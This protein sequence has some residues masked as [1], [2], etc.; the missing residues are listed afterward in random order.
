MR[1]NEKEKSYERQEE[2]EQKESNGKQGLLA[3]FLFLFLYLCAVSWRMTLMYEMKRT[4]TNSED[5]YEESTKKRHMESIALLTS[6]I[7]LTHLYVLHKYIF[8]GSFCLDLKKGLAINDKYCEFCNKQFV[9]DSD[10]DAII[11]EKI[12]GLNKIGDSYKIDLLLRELTKRGGSTDID[13]L[14]NTEFEAKSVKHLS[15]FMI[16]LLLI[17]SPIK[18]FHG[19]IIRGNLKITYENDDDDGYNTNDDDDIKEIIIKIQRSLAC[20]S[21]EYQIDN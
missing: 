3:H 8:K 6:H 20:I 14:G 12:K 17:N 7:S 21:R 15:W 5:D 11:E 16:Q 9:F 18:I 1:F 4:Y 2:C 10:D 19:D 13:I